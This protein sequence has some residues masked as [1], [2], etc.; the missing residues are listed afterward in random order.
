MTESISCPEGQFM[1]P[2]NTFV[3]KQ[4]S[5]AEQQWLSKHTCF[6]VDNSYIEQGAAEYT[7]QGTGDGGYFDKIGTR[8]VDCNAGHVNGGII[9]GLVGVD[10]HGHTE[11]TGATCVPLVKNAFA[12]TGPVAPNSNV[13][14]YKTCFGFPANAA[15]YHGDQDDIRHGGWTSCNKLR[16]TQ[17]HL[18]EVLANGVGTCSSFEVP[19]GVLALESDHVYTAGEKVALN[20][21]AGNVVYAKTKDGSWLP[22][23]Q[24]IAS[25]TCTPGGNFASEYSKC[26]AKPPDEWVVD[27]HVFKPNFASVVASTSPTQIEAFGAKPI[28]SWKSGDGVANCN[29]V[30]DANHANISHVVEYKN[31]QKVTTSCNCYNNPGCFH[32]S[33]RGAPSTTDTL[34]K[35][36]ELVDCPSLRSTYLFDSR[37]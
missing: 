15:H 8:L 33:Q 7:V 37:N 20:C 16:Q 21:D 34:M 4:M 35:R 6:P 30:C 3:T 22:T 31:N 19:N 18:I 17:K 12:S 10:I 36:I 5:E 29:K 2:P 9:K 26:A 25:M 23:T 27:K 28:T 24:T 32:T 13:W 1:Y 11:V 14:D